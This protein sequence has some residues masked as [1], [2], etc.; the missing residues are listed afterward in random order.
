MPDELEAERYAAD[1]AALTECRQKG[2]SETSI[3]QLAAECGIDKR[4]LSAIINVW[5]EA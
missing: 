1:I 4:D 5:G 2:V 3:R